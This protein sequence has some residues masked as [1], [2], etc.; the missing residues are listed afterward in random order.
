MVARGVESCSVNGASTGCV[1]QR[2][3]CQDSVVS[4]SIFTKI[5]INID[6]KIVLISEGWGWDSIRERHT[7]GFQERG[8][9]VAYFLIWIVE[10]RVSI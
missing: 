5:K 4:K 10:Y 1:V 3:F 2:E 9:I 6:I 8:L 7:K